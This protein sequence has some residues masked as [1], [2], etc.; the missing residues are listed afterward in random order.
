VHMTIEAVQSESFASVLSNASMVV[1]DGMPLIWLGRR[2]GFVLP[3]RVY[4]PDLMVH[5]LRSTQGRGYRHFFFGGAPGVAE[6]LV[7]NLQSQMDVNCV[8]TVSPPFRTLSPAED[9]EVVD[10]INSARPDIIWV[11][12]GCPKQERWM[13]EHSTKI[14]AAAMVGVGQAFDI[15]AGNLRQA[16]RIMRENGLEWL[17]RLC[18]EPRRLWRRY[19][20]Y[21]SKFIYYNV[22]QQLGL[23]DF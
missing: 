23:R 3:R 17:F 7:T 8:G 1:A 16:P 18:I 2:Q 12:L 21:N 15:H 6:K 5:F 14:E 13:F 4:G 9:Q 10:S 22:L 19:L 20:I 11:C